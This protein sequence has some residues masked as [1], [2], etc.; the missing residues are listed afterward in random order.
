MRALFP[1]LILLS[2]AGAPL[3]AL[4]ARI[5]LVGGV[6][7]SEPTEPGMSHQ[8]ANGWGGGVLME[9]RFV[10]LLGME[11]GALHLPRK[12]SFST[13]SPRSTTVT[14]AAKTYEFPLLLRLHMSRSFSF[15]I[16]GYYSTATGQISE[17]T[18][19]D[20]GASYR[21][22]TYA[23]AKQSRADFGL[24]SSLCLYFWVGPLLHWVVDAR[25]T[26]G[27]KNNHTD[28]G[29]KRFNDVQLLTGLQFGF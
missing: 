4:A 26:M 1:F 20:S 5:A 29:S 25:Y 6:N 16:G 3:P 22:L 15:G 28:G 8:A 13:A 19:S 23:E 17:E 7:I 14:R 9:F 24:A 27:L 11:F 10:P 2:L 12:H 21:T 18:V